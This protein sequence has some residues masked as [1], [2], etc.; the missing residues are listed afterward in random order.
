MVD[1][2]IFEGRT[3]DSYPPHIDVSRPYIR[4]ASIIFVLF[5]IAKVLV[6]QREPCRLAWKTVLKDYFV[7]LMV[8]S[9][10]K[11]SCMFRKI[12]GESV[13]PFALVNAILLEF[14]PILLDAS[15]ICGDFC[16]VHSDVSIWDADSIQVCLLSE[17]RALPYLPVSVTL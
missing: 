3:V 6:S 2:N 15:E 5:D 7:K 14:L 11:L 16:I 4:E 17:V 10:C 1:F 8:E 9:S 12:F 13:L